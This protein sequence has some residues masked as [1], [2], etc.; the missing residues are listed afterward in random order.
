M[1]ILK[2]LHSAASMAARGVPAVQ[3][4]I[5]GARI[6]ARRFAA[7]T[8]ETLGIKVAPVAA[9]ALR[10]MDSSIVA[11]EGVA[12]M[13]RLDSIARK[14]IALGVSPTGGMSATVSQ[15]IV[16]AA[17]N[18]TVRGALMNVGRATAV[19]ALGGAAIDVALAT[20]EVVPLVRGNK[21]TRDAAARRVGKRA[22]RGAAS[23]AAGVAAAAIVS[24]GV[25]ASGL[26]IAAAP[27][28]VP[29]V[30][31]MAVGTLVS[32]AFDRKFGTT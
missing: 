6:G 32:R 21:I 14:G 10:P 1:M 16:T 25:A 27:V 15:E 26:T 17:A 29:F 3:A 7:S 30:G 5:H 8:L 12:P 18:T 23:G 28:V 2:A 4:A 24:A 20:L 13:I 31:M 9:V 11:A 22:L 19:G